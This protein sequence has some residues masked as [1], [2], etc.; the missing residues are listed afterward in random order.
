MRVKTHVPSSV[1]RSSTD[2]GQEQWGNNYRA[3]KT[4]R[5]SQF[6]QAYLC[7][8]AWSGM[9]GQ[10]EAITSIGTGCCMAYLKSNIISLLCKIVDITI[11]HSLLL[12]SCFLHHY[13]YRSHW[14][15]AKAKAAPVS[16]RSW[17]PCMIEWVDEASK[18]QNGQL[19]Y[20]TSSWA[21]K[22]GPTGSS[23]WLGCPATNRVKSSARGPLSTGSPQLDP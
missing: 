7:G 13:L 14:Q 8:N 22:I 9:D 4:A 17:Q 2:E 10:K 11:A 19:S 16:N 15:Q 1:D 3:A 20:S 23:R 12:G 5:E 18:Q 21:V 6:T